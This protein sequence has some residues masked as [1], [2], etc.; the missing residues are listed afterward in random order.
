MVAES[1]VGL[2][3]IAGVG[4][5]AVERVGETRQQAEKFGWPTEYG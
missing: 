2:A 5:L 4:P 1:V 3:S